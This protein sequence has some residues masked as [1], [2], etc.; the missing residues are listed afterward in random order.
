M[1]QIT[2]VLK[3]Q[4]ADLSREIR[5]LE[6]QKG[7]L[8]LALASFDEGSASSVKSAA[9]P[10]PAATPRAKRGGRR[11]RGA[12]QQRVLQALG[13]TPRRLT[14]IASA[15]SLS[16]TAAGGVLRALIAKGHVS[17][18]SKRGTYV[19]KAVVGERKAFGRARSAA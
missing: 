3:T 18:G 7:A 5:K 12:N 6:A 11:K 2:S 8:L 17:K 19:L 10:A 9:V 16:L 14:D 15:A 1:H 4:I 13:K